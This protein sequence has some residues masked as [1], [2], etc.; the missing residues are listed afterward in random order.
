MFGTVTVHSAYRH[1]MMLTQGS[2][3][4]LWTSTL[5]HAKLHE[6]FPGQQVIL[7]AD[8]VLANL[9]P[10]YVITK[11]VESMLRLP[12]LMSAASA[13]IG[14]YLFHIGKQARRPRK[15]WQWYMGLIHLLGVV[16]AHS[17]LFSL[18]PHP[19]GLKQ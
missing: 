13:P 15:N 11:S 10:L 4:L 2:V 16:T 17:Y 19:I 6:T 8:K 12:L 18:R 3:C 5:T 1:E 9:L 7:G 14:V